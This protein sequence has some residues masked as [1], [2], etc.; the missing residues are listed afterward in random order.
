LGVVLDV[1]YL[2]IV[3]L[4]TLTFLVIAAF[5]TALGIYFS[6]RSTT[7]LRAMGLTLASTL[8]LGGGYLMCCCPVATALGAGDVMALAMAPCMPFLL[9]APSLLMEEVFEW[10]VVAAYCLGMI[11]YSG[12]LVVML[13]AMT[14]NFDALAGRTDD[15]PDATQAA[16]LSTPA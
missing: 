6:L 13:R 8:F 12:A 14:A 16:G 2:A 9:L 4:S 10:A 11:G 3:A 1:R 15:M 5:V 7:S